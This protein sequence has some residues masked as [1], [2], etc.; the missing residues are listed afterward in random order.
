MRGRFKR[1]ELLALT[2]AA[3]GAA[4]WLI[5]PAVYLRQGPAAD[6]ADSVPRA[7][8]GAMPVPRA[9][10][11]IDGL[12]AIVT[13]PLF[14]ATRRPASRAPGSD[15]SLIL[16]KY[17]LTG[18]VITPGKRMI[19]MRTPGSGATVAVHQ[20]EK[21]DGWSVTEVTATKIVLQAA[22]RRVVISNKKAGAGTGPGR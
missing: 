8:P 1:I 17:E 12:A 18:R 19:L 9:I 14:T 5:D 10:P 20:G 7:V 11:P 16:G 13:R 6:V 4:P 22:H 3:L 21:I 15:K 2:L